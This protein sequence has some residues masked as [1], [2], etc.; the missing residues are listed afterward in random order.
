MLGEGA[1]SFSSPGNNNT[2]IGVMTL[3]TLSA[4]GGNTAVG[5]NALRQAP[6][7]AYGLGSNNT[8]LGSRALSNGLSGNNNV[9]IGVSSMDV[10][11][12]GSN[13]TAVGYYSSVSGNATNST[14]IGNGASNSTSN[15]IQLGN[16][17]ITNVKTSGTITAGVVTYPK[18]DGAPNQVL[19]TN[20]AGLLSWATPAGLP[21]SGNTAGD[22]LY[23]NGSAWVKV[24]AGANGQTLAFANSKPYWTGTISYV[25]TVK[26]ATGRIWMDRNVGASRVATS[27]TDAEA[28]GGLFQWGRGAD[29]HESRTTL[30]NNN[31]STTDTPGHGDFIKAPDG[32]GWNWRNPN[33]T[34]LW[35]GVTGINNVCPVGF[36]IPT[37]AEWSA[38]K[39][40]W[41]TPIDVFNTP[42]KLTLGGHHHPNV[43][44][45]WQVGGSG[46]YWSSSVDSYGWPTYLSLGASSAVT[47][48]AQ[49]AHGFSIRCIKD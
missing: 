15:T 42:L 48:I 33:N 17:S 49:P 20:G 6:S 3:S 44:T 18:T 12:P 19:S 36:R 32:T 29:G 5:S 10:N 24:A 21:S 11:D 35:Q 16:T 43:A 8:A 27:A 39:A 7:G 41:A 45:P 47:G 31:W 26:T 22:M 2:A 40:T 28:Y 1:F 34:Q 37:A 46:S 9:A 14:A 30:I 13:N 25:N 4:G 23:W 38:E